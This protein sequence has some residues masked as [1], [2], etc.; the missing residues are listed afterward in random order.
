MALLLDVFKLLAAG[1]LIALA[2]ASVFNMHRALMSYPFQVVYAGIGIAIYAV[3]FGK[4]RVVPLAKKARRKNVRRIK[5][6]RSNVNDWREQR[7]EE[8]MMAKGIMPD[9]EDSFGWTR[10]EEE[11]IDTP[12]KLE[13]LPVPP[14]PPITEIPKP[15]TTNFADTD[16]LPNVPIKKPTPKPR[17]RPVEVIEEYDDLP[18]VPSPIAPKQIS[19]AP[20]LPKPE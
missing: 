13:T 4:V 15:L 16:A 5:D 12:P 17:P 9:P 8:K 7:T 18:Q 1:Y 6:I 3:S 19:Q 14:V 11:P 10:I 2:L 20:K